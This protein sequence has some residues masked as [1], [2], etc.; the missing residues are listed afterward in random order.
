LRVV[1]DFPEDVRV[2]ENTW[3]PMRDG[4]HLAARLWMPATAEEQPVPA[5]IEY[6]PYRKRD[7]TRMRDEPLNQYFAGHGYIG[8]RLDV[9]GT[10][11]SE[12]ILR[13][14][15][16]AQEQDD[17]EDAI[18]WLT[19][20]PWCDGNIGMIGLS[21]S[22]FNA[23]QVAA[24]QPPGLGAIIT[25]CST[26]DRYADDAHYKGGCL[27]NENLGWGSALFSL[28]ACPPDPEIAGD[29]WREQWHQRLANNQPFPALWMQHPHRDDYWKHG[30]VCEDFSAIDCAVYA[31]S[32]WADG[33]VNA[34]PRMLEGLDVPRKGLIGPWPH[35]FPHAAAPGPRIGFFQEAVRWWDYWLKGIDTGIMDEPMLR[36]WM[37]DWIPPAPSHDERPGR[38][39]AEE[40]WPSPRITRRRWYLNV[41]SLGDEA[42]SEDRM[43][44]RSPQTTGLKGGDFYG[45]GADG[46]APLDQRE[47]DGRSLAFDSDPLTQRIE[48]LGAPVVTL[49]FS[50]DQPVAHIAVRLNDV[51]PDGS[52]GR[53]TYETFNLCHRD[54]HE[55]PE[56]LE[57]GKRYRVPIQLNDIG[58]AFA[59]GHTIRVAI[60][61][62]YWPM[63]WP[64]PAPVELTIYTGASTLDLP[65]RPPR[66]ADADLAPFPDPERGP[67]PSHTP[68]EMT[69]PQ[70][71]IETDLTTDET[72]YTVV[73]DSGDFGGAAVA[74]IDD[75]DLTLGYS[76]EKIFRIG[77]HDPLTA[78]A[79]MDQT[80]TFERG[81][82]FVRIECLTALTADAE[83]FYVYATQRAFEGDTE[84]DHRE[85]NE[86]I[87]RR[88][89]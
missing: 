69:E 61:T 15:Y 65:V 32:G 25:M 44:V 21:W 84:V 42:G 73:G 6:M 29:G 3:I 63:I 79:T 45:F 33:Y 78:S 82:W 58:Y 71:T 16:V 31:V 55:Y 64:A 70:R 8:V 66:D 11:D 24:R 56:A 23:L 67:E 68:L 77:Q 28:N 51:A 52:S 74:R 59:P 75:I 88:L 34:V 41:L 27:L 57:P 49:E 54:S 47:D 38:W 48:I 13:D 86:K 81:D 87:P 72:I 40:Q 36:A 1:E 37:E 5:I 7:F 20:Q 62:T 60:S 17:A 35:A 89:L 12:G 22:G 10:G 46:D 76:M 18:A 85:W 43:R 53:V 50:V 9:R 83:H 14:E 39:V 2:I 4:V 19:Q 80:T 26:D 30:S